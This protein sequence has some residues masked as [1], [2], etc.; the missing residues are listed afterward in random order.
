MI[1]AKKLINL[2]IIF[3]PVLNLFQ[4]KYHYYLINQNLVF[5][6]IIMLIN[7]IINKKAINKKD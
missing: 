3:N 5:L 6:I 1:F 2:L 4:P 7:Q